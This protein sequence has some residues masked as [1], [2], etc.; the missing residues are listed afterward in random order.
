SSD[1]IPLD[2]RLYLAWFRFCIASKGFQALPQAGISISTSPTIP[3]RLLLFLTI[4]V[5]PVV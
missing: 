2:W 1:L 4:V 3:L 5:V